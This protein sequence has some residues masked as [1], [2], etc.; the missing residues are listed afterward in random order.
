V[1]PAEQEILLRLLP[2]RT[3]VPDQSSPMSIPLSQRGLFV[4][5]ERSKRKI[6]PNRH[7]EQDP[8]IR[9]V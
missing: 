9:Y 5:Q 2:P 8:D 7:K 4:R 6:L 1:P 3:R